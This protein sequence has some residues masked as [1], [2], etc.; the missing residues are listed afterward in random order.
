MDA[1]VRRD[2]SNKAGYTTHLIIDA[3]CGLT[4]AGCAQAVEELKAVPYGVEVLTCEDV[5]KRFGPQ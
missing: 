4:V 3:S 1:C 5:H 2:G